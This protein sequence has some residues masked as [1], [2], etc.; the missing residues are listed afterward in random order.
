M[1]AR[2]LAGLFTYGGNHCLQQRFGNGTPRPLLSIVKLRIGI[3]GIRNFCLLQ[4]T[5]HK[6]SEG[7]LRRGG[8]KMAGFPDAPAAYPANVSRFLLPAQRDVDA[9]MNSHFLRR[10]P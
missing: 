8:S 3:D 4:F 9:I 7:H 6:G 10:R 2:L 5:G 1:M